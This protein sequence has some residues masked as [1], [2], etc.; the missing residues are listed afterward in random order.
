MAIADSRLSLSPRVIF[1]R[2]SLEPLEFSSEVKFRSLVQKLIV[3]KFS[4]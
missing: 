4:L 1:K 2:C 3:Q